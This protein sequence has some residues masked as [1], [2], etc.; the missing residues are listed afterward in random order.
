MQITKDRQEQ[1]IREHKTLLFDFDGTI[2]AYRK[3]WQDGSIYDEPT[4]DVVETMRMLTK[5]GFEIII[6]TARLN[7]DCVPD[8]DVEWKK[9]HAWL[10]KWGIHQGT[11]YQSMTCKKIGCLMHVDD[12]VVRYE[13]NWSSIRNLLI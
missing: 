2:H 6:F 1:E 4:P 9:M 13:G 12:R 3:G 8:V 5:K 7:G 11:H 10:N